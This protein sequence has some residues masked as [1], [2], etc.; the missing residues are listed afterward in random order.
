[1][2]TFT[3]VDNNTH[4]FHEIPKLTTPKVEYN[5][6]CNGQ[7]VGHTYGQHNG[8]LTVNLCGQGNHAFNVSDI[9]CYLTKS[10][11]IHELFSI[12]KIIA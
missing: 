12:G 10:I 4:V 7:F 9:E 1:M 5:M 3:K 8:L 2:I 6:Y 11:S